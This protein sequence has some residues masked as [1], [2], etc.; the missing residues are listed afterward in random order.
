MKIKSHMLHQKE[1]ATH[2]LQ[3][4]SKRLDDALQ[5]RLRAIFDAKRAGFSVRKIASECRLSPS[6]VHQILSMNAAIIETH[7]STQEVEVIENEISLRNIALFNGIDDIALTSFTRYLT[8]KRFPKG[9]IL[10]QEGE[11]SD[12]MYIILSGS[13]EIYT[14]DSSGKEAVLNSLG[15]GDCLGELA[16][17]D[18]QPR[19]ASARTISQSKMLVLTRAAFITVV[20]SYPEVG[21]ELLALLSGKLREQ[22]AITRDLALKTTYERLIAAFHDLGEQSENGITIQNITHQ[23]L[24]NRIHASREMVTRIINDLKQGGYIEVSQR[25]IVIKKPLPAFW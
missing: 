15:S 9:M 18:G 13:I 16:L 24:A 20:K 17:L 25:R 14:N 7:E 5:E 21:L 1:H 6:R 12:S 11:Y 4:A 3:Y 8:L 19:S 2:Q 10:I 23:R 22:T